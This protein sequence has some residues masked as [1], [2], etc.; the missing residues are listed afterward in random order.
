MQQKRFIK[1]SNQ[2][3]MF[4]AIISSILRSTEQLKFHL[5][6]VTGRQQRRCIIPQ[7]VNTVCAPGDGRNYRPKHVELIR[8]INL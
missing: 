7:A 8:I 4:R 6:Q 5:I 3:N 1:N 2:L